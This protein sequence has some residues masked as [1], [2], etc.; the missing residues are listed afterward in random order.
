LT[1]PVSK[2]SKKQLNIMLY[3]NEEG[4]QVDLDFENMKFDPYAPFEGVIN[5]LQRWFANPYSETIREWTE[6]YMVMRLLRWM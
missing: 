2:L 1:T 6:D 3:G 4:Q 5:M